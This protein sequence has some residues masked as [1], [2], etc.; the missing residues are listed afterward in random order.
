VPGKKSRLATKVATA[1]IGAA[2]ACVLLA[3]CSTI[4][5]GSAAVVG[6]TTITTSSLDAQVSSV[7]ATAAQHHLTVQAAPGRT[8]PQTVLG[9]MINFHIRDRMAQDAGISVTDA[10]IQAELDSL[11]K[12]QQQQAASSGSPYPGLPALLAEN[13]ISPE[14]TPDFGKYEAQLIAYVKN[15]NGGA[16]PTSQADAQ[17]ALA[18]VGTADCR[19]RKALAIQV[20]PQF[21]QL[22]YDPASSLYTV[23]A[24]TD[25][26]SRPAG[27]PSPPSTAPPALPAC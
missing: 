5:M 25:T 27:E 22:G 13:G 14:M 24:S 10:Q 7:Q 9:W 20:N 23:L 17:K 15:G 26:L 2:G 4:K 18:A 16:L 19:A 12:S 3:A 21:G 11:D 8:V 1:V 6:G